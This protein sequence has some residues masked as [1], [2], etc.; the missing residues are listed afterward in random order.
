[1]RTRSGKQKS[2]FKSFKPSKKAAPDVAQDFPTDW[3]ETSDASCRPEESLMPLTSVQA[4]THLAD[5]PV[6]WK[7]LRADVQ[8]LMKAGL[9][10]PNA[11]DSVGQD[12]CLHTSFHLYDHVL[13]LL[14]MM[15]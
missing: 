14:S 9:E 11:L 6:V 7:K 5:Y 3:I 15:Y 10:Y 12:K 4:R 8:L 13:M 2:S 1:M